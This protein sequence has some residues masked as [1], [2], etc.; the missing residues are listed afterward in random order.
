MIKNKNKIYIYS[1]KD[2]EFL[3]FILFYFFFK[4]KKKKYDLLY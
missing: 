3:F 4:K 2:K 1:I